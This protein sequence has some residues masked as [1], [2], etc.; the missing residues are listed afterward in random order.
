MN[1]FGK[2]SAFLS[3]FFASVA[4]LLS[5]CGGGGGG[6]GSN[7]SATSAPPSSSDSGSGTGKIVVVAGDDDISEWDQALFQISEIILLGGSDGQVVIDD[8][9]RVIDF[10]ALD[11]VNEV[12]ADAEV[13]ADTYDKLRFEV[14]WIKLVKLVDP[15][16]PDAGIAEEVMVQQSSHKVDVNPQGSF[17]VGEDQNL[18]VQID[19]DLEKSLK[20]HQTGNGTWK[21][22]PVI[23]ATI[24]TV[25]EP[26]GLVR[27]F[28]NDVQLLELGED[29]PDAFDLCDVQSIAEIDQL[30]DPEDCVRVVLNDG[31]SVFEIV[32]DEGTES[33]QLVD[34]DAIGDMDAAVVYGYVDPS[35]DQFTVDAE[36][37]A[38]ATDE[39]TYTI[40]ECEAQGSAEDVDGVPTFPCELET[41]EPDEPTDGEAMDDTDV[42]IDI[43][44][45]EGSKLYNLDGEPTDLESIKDGAPIE[46]EGDLVDNS[47]QE[48]VPDR[49]DAFVAF[50]DEDA[51]DQVEG[52]LAAIDLPNRE[53]TVIDEDDETMQWCVVYDDDTVFYK[54]VDD[55]DGDPIESGIVTADELQEGVDID[56]SGTFVEDCLQASEIVL[57]VSGSMDDD[58]MDDDSMDGGEEGT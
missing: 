44:L 24:L 19:V 17:T 33:L 14:D 53:L 36:I 32:D 41:D 2:R 37:V 47:D 35:A 31:T 18:V 1:L 38:I 9:V 25:D 27:V 42:V 5:A 43:A 6:G 40:V 52:M 45:L 49:L 7:T 16:D 21:F 55:E 58:S 3:A 8:Q 56:A 28:G 57:E 11:T 46:A 26:G 12:L 22:R 39:D 13:P 15:A 10:L 4:L 34:P 23:F 50:V 48:D 29:E 20:A 30:D 51:E 54:V